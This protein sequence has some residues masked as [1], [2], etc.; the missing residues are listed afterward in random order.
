MVDKVS[1]RAEM[2]VLDARDVSTLISDSGT[3]RYRIKA[4]VWQIYDQA[5]PPHWLFPEGIYLERFSPD[6]SVDAY[7]Q[8]DS[9]YYNTE[10]Q[11]WHL[12]G[13]VEARNLEGERFNTPELF[14]TEKEEQIYSDTLITITKATS[15]IYG[16]GFR[17][18]Q[19]MTRYT[20]L[21]PTGHALL[22]EN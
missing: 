16:V 14:W 11:Q 13:N 22:Q 10:L 19:Q 17:S 15:V 20:I 2:P 5:T 7:M 1:N 6:L 3:V 18:N 12:I 4:A 21:R 9:A 8:A